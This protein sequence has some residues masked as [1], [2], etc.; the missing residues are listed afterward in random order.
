M[1]RKKSQSFEGFWM[2]GVARPRPVRESAGMT[3]AEIMCSNV[4]TI[5]YI[6]PAYD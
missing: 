4:K 1:E 6:P 3:E 5:A 2:P